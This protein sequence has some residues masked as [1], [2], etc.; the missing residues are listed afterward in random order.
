MSDHPLRIVPNQSKPPEAAEEAASAQTPPGALVTDQEKLTELRRLLLAPEQQQIAQLQARLNDHKGR[1][2]DLGRALPDA[3]R[4]R[5]AQDKALTVA[6]TPNIEPALRQ[7]IKKD[8]SAVIAAVTP[9]I[10]PAI[11]SA[12]SRALNEFLQSLDETLKHGLSAQGMKWRWEAFRTGRR[13]AEVVLYHTLVYRVERAFL[14]HR[15]TGLLLAHADAPMAKVENP[16]LVSGLLTAINDLGRDSFQ[17]TDDESLIKLDYGE[18]EVWIEGG[19][20]PVEL[21]YLAVVI[22]G[23][24]PE[25]LRNE[26]LLPELEAIH[27]KLREALL[28]FEG[29]T[30]PFELSHEHLEACLQSQYQG[31]AAGE[32]SKVS[33]LPLRVSLPVAALLLLL[34]VWA[35]FDWRAERRWK[36]YLAKLQAEP[37][38]VVTEQGRSGRLLGARFFIAGL[39]DPLAADPAAI[40][41]QTPL[42]PA[43]VTSRWKPYYALDADIVQARAVSVLEPPATVSLKLENGVL[44]ASGSAS[45]QWSEN[46]R[47]LCRALP[48]ITRFDDSA[49]GKAEAQEQLRLKDIV[50]KSSLRFNQ[51]TTDFAPGQEAALQSLSEQVVR[52]FALRPLTGKQPRLIIVGHTDAEGGEA[53]NQRLSL[54]RATQ[55]LNHLI[56]KGVPRDR[57]QATGVG[58]SDPLRAENTEEDRQFNR[59]VSF[60]VELP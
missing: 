46:A 28:D 22:R 24:A 42:D 12:I 16:D 20:P 40:L 33:R 49:L 32:K 53:I 7:A 17:A 60:R 56:A 2:K 5:N 47:R 41:R 19:A 43:A 27:S 13:F 54:D 11:R 15:Q 3:I 4:A 6:L 58:N 31:K 30:G 55:V 36:D 1:V 34:M 59:R 35:F 48:G 52:L 18:L 23:N 51:G 57:L 8:P 38:L 44:T 26:V 21:A 25:N 29:D 14:F 39:R 37:G 9:V 45:Q 10:G 50:E